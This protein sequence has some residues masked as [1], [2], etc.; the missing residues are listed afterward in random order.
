[1]GAN[2]KQLESTG[3]DVLADFQ[4]ARERQIDRKK[5]D[6]RCEKAEMRSGAMY[7]CL[8]QLGN[9]LNRRAVI[10]LAPISDLNE[11]QL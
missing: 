10:V 7:P 1:M 11:D 8:L 9:G 6:T 4:S 5:S 3:T 2:K